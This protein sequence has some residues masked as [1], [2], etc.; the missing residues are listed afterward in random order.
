MSGE[1]NDR[2]LIVSTDIVTIMNHP[3]TKQSSQSSQ[4][5][6]GLADARYHVPSIARKLPAVT[7]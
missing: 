5:R 1:K 6:I 4:I 2:H 3:Q 7:P